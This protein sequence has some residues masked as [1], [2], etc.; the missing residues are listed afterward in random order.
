FKNT[1]IVM[2]SNIGSQ[3]IQKMD[4]DDYAAIKAVVMEDV[5]QYFRPELIN[6]IDEVV[7]FHS[8]NKSNIRAI[9]NIQLAG[10]R[11]RLESMDLHLQVDDAALDALAEVG[12][13]P[14]YGARPLK[15][16]IQTEIENPLAK[17]LLAGDYAPGSTIMLTAQDGILTFA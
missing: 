14:V 11:K 1:V 10:L 9:A 7:V 6:R 16:A 15:R 17:E 2:T 3:E 5:K 13:D 8:L 4:T 12:F